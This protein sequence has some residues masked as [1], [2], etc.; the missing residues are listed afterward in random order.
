[1]ATNLFANVNSNID[2]NSYSDI[3]SDTNSSFADTPTNRSTTT[4]STLT[5]T[6]QDTTNQDQDTNINS[7]TNQDTNINSTSTTTID[8][9]IRLARSDFERS[10]KEDDGSGV[11]IELRQAQ[12]VQSLKHI[13]VSAQDTYLDEMLQ[14]C[15]C[16]IF[17]KTKQTKIKKTLLFLNTPEEE[18]PYNLRTVNELKDTYLTLHNETAP[19]LW[20]AK[21]LIEMLVSKKNMLDLRVK[22]RVSH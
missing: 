19:A 20:S 16:I 4:T 11:S 1:M 6:N 18:R 7:T 2:T 21:N 12:Y 17:P 3:Y 15:N 14:L 13:G 5:I 9:N 8:I 22:I 10:T